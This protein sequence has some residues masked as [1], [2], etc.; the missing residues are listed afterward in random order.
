[1][2][3]T[4][5]FSIPGCT[6]RVVFTELGAFCLVRAILGAVPRASGNTS[7]EVRLSAI[8][9]SHVS[10]NQYPASERENGLGTAGCP[11]AQCGNR[12]TPMSVLVRIYPRRS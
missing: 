6:A 8:G 9:S 10:K 3:T 11:L 1:M 7:R 4:F 5:S 2:G 12:S